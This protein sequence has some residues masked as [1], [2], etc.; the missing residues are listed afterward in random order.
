MDDNSSN[1]SCNKGDNIEMKVVTSYENG[2]C[3]FNVKLQ[4]QHGLRLVVIQL[5]VVTL[6]KVVLRYGNN[7]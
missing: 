5:K 7:N 2:A 3:K 6:M 4:K 1:F